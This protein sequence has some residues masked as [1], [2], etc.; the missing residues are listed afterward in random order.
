MNPCPHCGRLYTM[1]VV[2]DD[3]N[4][5]GEPFR[6][7][8]IE[9]HDCPKFRVEPPLLPFDPTFRVRPDTP[10]DKMAALGRYREWL[11]SEFGR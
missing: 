11:D 6:I 5:A 1:R 2:W 3:S 8:E 9:D 7:H 10:D 4:R